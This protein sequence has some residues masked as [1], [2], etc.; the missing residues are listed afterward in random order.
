M[1]VYFHYANYTKRERFHIDA[2]GGGIKRSAVGRTLASRAFHLL[3]LDEPRRTVKDVGRWKGDSIAI[4]G[5]DYL[6]DWDKFMQEFVDIAAN[7]IVLLYRTD[8]FQ[9]IA[10]AAETESRLFMQLCHL[11]VTRQVLDLERHMKE[12]FGERF[13]R[14][15]QEIASRQGFEPLYIVD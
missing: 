13:L 14:R 4:V 7:T 11:V 3:L 6:P 1:G 9:T 15:Y 12:R 2:L 8:G 5:D 10:E